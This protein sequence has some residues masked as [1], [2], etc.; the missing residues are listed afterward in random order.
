NEYENGKII[1]SI[2][3]DSNGKIT[4][5]DDYE[6]FPEENKEVITSTSY[7]GDNISTTTSTNIYDKSNNLISTVYLSKYNNHRTTYTYDNKNRKTSRKEYE[8]SS[9]EEEYM[10]T[11][12]EYNYD[13]KG[14]SMHRQSRYYIDDELKE[15][16]LTFDKDCN[17]IS[18]KCMEGNYVTHNITYFV[19][20][21]GESYSAM[22]YTTNVKQTAVKHKIQL[23]K[24]DSDGNP[25]VRFPVIKF[26]ENAS[27]FAEYNKRVYKYKYYDEEPAIYYYGFT[28]YKNEILNDY[29]TD[30]DAKKCD[31]V[32]YKNKAYNVKYEKTQEGTYEVTGNDSGNEIA[33]N[34]KNL[35]GMMFVCTDSVKLK[36][37]QTVIFCND[38]FLND[39][40]IV[41]FVPN[42]KNTKADASVIAEMEKIYKNKVTRSR[43]IATFGENK[44]YAMQ[45]DYSD[46]DLYALA[47]YV[48]NIDGKNYVYESLARPYEGSFWRI[49]D[50]G[51]F[52]MESSLLLGILNSRDGY[53]FIIESLGAEGSMVSILG[54]SD[55]ML[56]EETYL[57]G[58]GR[59]WGAY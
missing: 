22:E 19:D 51:E 29:V 57:D 5:R 50:D 55:S 40:Q 20:S 49:D 8:F 6:Y 3:Y 10:T 27:G 53:K 9:E 32:I 33:E 37:D 17:L 4:N 11:S 41:E 23:G 52:F 47:L 18:F 25:L 2:K 58:Y 45:F 44:F 7:Y 56:V 46:D 42:T 59:Y 15:E 26:D 35:P 39:Y 38:V 14:Y 28:C 13:P 54:I 12:V 21:D 24:D 36:S 48:V 16:F 30:E 1:S 43:L 31:K 34:A